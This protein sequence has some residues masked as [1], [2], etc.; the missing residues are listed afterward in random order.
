LDGYEAT[1][2]IRS[3]QAGMY[4]KD[5]PIIA[6]TANALKGDREKCLEAGMNDHIPKPIMVDVLKNRLEAALKENQPV[7]TECCPVS[8]Q[9]LQTADALTESVK[10]QLIIPKGIKT[11]DWQLSPP[12]LIDQ[13]QAFLKGLRIYIK[14]YQ[15]LNITDYVS[16]ASQ[17]IIAS[18]DL[19]R[20]VHTIKGTSGSMGFIHLYELSIKV[21]KSASE[22]EILVEEIK[23]WFHSI[24]YSV[25]DAKA[26]LA[27]NKRIMSSTKSRYPKNPILSELK[28]IL[29][30]SEV[31][32]QH[33][34]DELEQLPQA[35]LPNQSKLQLI[36][37][38]EHF[39]YDQALTILSDNKP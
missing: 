13:A 21:E 24:E 18:E 9:S 8:D 10:Q 2:Q 17:Q 25:E 3:G 5:V 16:K 4:Y 7:K 35:C 36:E 38:I 15:E 23:Q 32:S 34:L 12:T 39:D 33:L 26:I 14:Q 29:E 1:R 31:V 6:M 30:R 11:M 19:K 28:P 20:L 27:A 37:A 22:G